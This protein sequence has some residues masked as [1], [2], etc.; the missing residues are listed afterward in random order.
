M[1]FGIFSSYL[2]GTIELGRLVPNRAIF[3]ILLKG[4]EG[5]PLIKFGII[6]L[7]F[8]EGECDEWKRF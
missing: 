2:H 4:S 3:T 6:E 5:V 7:T 8:K 1:L